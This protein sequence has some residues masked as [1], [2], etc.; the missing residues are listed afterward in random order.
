MKSKKRLLTTVCIFEGSTRANRETRIRFNRT[1]M[2]GSITINA[3]STNAYALTAA[4]GCQFND[5]IM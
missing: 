3:G 2:S 4:E 5:N 1:R